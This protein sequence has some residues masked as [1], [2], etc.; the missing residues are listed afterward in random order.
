M[1][2]PPCTGLTGANDPSSDVGKTGEDVACREL[3]RRGHAILARGCRT[4]HGELDIVVRDGDVLVFVEVTTRSSETF[5]SPLEAVTA[6]K[7]TKLIRMA[8]EYLSRS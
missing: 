7:R 1:R 6:R 4:R 8:R 5:G 3:S 2:P